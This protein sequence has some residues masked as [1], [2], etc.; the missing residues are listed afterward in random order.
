LYFENRDANQPS[1]ETIPFLT[2]LNIHVT[3]RQRT[4]IY[5]SVSGIYQINIFHVLVVCKNSKLII[6]D[7]QQSTIIFS[8]V[9]VIPQTFIDSNSLNCI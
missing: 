1:D 6:F 4:L 3:R 9:F 2:G 7:K 8:D 5:I